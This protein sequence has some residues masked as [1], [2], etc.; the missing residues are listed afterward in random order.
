M[1]L[2]LVLGILAGCGDV[3]L[4]SEADG[5]RVVGEELT[6]RGIAA[7]A[8][9]PFGPVAVDGVAVTF[10]LDGWSDAATFGFE[11]VSD[12]DPDFTEATTDLGAIAE[13]PKLQAAVDATLPAGSQILVIRT[14]GHETEAL[15]EDQLR[16]Y[17]QQ[18][19]DALGR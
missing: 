9:P 11:Y 14:W 1:R 18:Q 17:V 5:V 8:T 4:V 15:A 10:T 6:A 13:T 2:A 3:Y 7:T 12:G 16:G 19:L